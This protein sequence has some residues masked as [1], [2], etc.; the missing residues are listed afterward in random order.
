MIRF[1]VEGGTSY[2]ERGNEEVR[3]EGVTERREVERSRELRGSDGLQ[4]RRE[5]RFRSFRN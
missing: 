1:V 2:D 4:W 3:V 5:V